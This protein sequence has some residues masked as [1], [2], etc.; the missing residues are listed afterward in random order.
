ML[1]DKE[2]G[3]IEGKINTNKQVNKNEN[4]KKR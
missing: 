3:R 4:I 1:Q 2:W